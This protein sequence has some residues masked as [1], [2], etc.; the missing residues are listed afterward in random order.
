[1][2]AEHGVT[3]R[4]IAPEGAAT[5]AAF[6]YVNDRTGENAIIVVPGAAATITA[7]DVEREADAIRGAKVFM[8]QLELPVATARRGLAIARAA[9]VTTVFNPAPAEAFDDAMYGLCDFITPN[10]TE[11]SM[12]TG[13]AVTSPDDAGARAT[14]CWRRAPARC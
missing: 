10:E 5:G 7:A 6:I 11:A 2:W 12:L 9:G 3:A 1:M 13:V 8:T 4:L 14:C